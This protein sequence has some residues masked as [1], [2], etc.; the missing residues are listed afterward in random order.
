MTATAQVVN[1]K[2]TASPAGGTAPVVESSATEIIVRPS[3]S[4]YHVLDRADEQLIEQE[5]LGNLVEALVYEFKVSGKP[6]R[7][8]S[9]AGVNHAVRTLNARGVARIKCPP[10]P[11]PEFEDC[12]DEEGD[13]AWRCTVYAVDALTDGGAWGTA[14][15]KKHMQLQ[16]GSSKPDTFSRTKALSKAQR[17][18][19]SA[20]IS[21][22][23]KA[24]IIL[25]LS[26]N[27]RNVQTIQSQAEA[28]HAKEL[29]PPDTSPE[30][31]ELNAQ[32]ETLIGELEALGLIPAKVKALGD[33]L[34]A[35]R[36]LEE[37]GALS[38]RLAGDLEK[39]SK[40]K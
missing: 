7:G 12:I 8:L 16:N 18:A 39:R 4:L 9:Y 15:Q 28:H 6:V 20:L 35:T 13:A 21:E 22:E 11:R 34:A 23:L 5:I 1:E 32:C 26:G 2:G 29:P 40:A 30:A 19:K 3:E 25:A 31:R 33:A 36:T 37:K 24:Q 14:Q 10:S 17:N 38:E 27:R